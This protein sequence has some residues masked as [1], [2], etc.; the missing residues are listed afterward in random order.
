MYV[1]YLHYCK[2]RRKIEC[3]LFGFKILNSQ[4]LWQN[5]NTVECNL[6]TTKKIFRIVMRYNNHYNKNN[7]GTPEALHE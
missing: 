2:S 6:V 1:V 5:W 3:K 4:E 7:A